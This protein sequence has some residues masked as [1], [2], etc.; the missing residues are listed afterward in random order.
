MP[1]RDRSAPAAIA[2]TLVCA[3]RDVDIVAGDSSAA[4]EL[5]RA[6]HEDVGR[7]LTSARLLP[8]VEVIE[9]RMTMMRSAVS[10]HRQTDGRAFPHRVTAM[11]AGK[12][13][14][15]T[16]RGQRIRIHP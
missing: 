3:I 14:L 12:R 10:Q 11:R 13:V 6:D 1:P 7:R 2:Q 5:A 4:A 16:I 8:I 9:T 15:V